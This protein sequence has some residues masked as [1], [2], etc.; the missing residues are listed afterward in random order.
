VC[1]VEQQLGNEGQAPA[2]LLLFRSGGRLCALRLE[3]V[4]ETT[5]PLPIE[6]IAGTP[7]SCSA[8]R[9]C[10]VSSMP[11]VD[12]ARLFGAS[13]TEAIKQTGMFWAVVNEPP[14]QTPV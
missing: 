2:R 9:S 4:R 7:R 10:E 3:S 12:P 11:V 5:R 6:P 1:P 14:P 13:A 8:S